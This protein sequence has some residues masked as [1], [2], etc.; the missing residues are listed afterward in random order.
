MAKRYNLLESKKTYRNIR[1][2]DTSRKNKL[3]A[4]NGVK[5]YFD[6][7]RSQGYGGYYYDGRWIKI[8]KA[9]TKFRL[10]KGSKILDIGCAKGFL[11]RF[12]K[13]ILK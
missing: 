7:N 2:R 12:K 6:G 4:S 8:A 3:L 9:I 13:T 5:E 10:K 11:M 1:D